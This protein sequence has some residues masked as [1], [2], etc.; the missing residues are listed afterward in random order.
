MILHPRISASTKILGEVAPEQVQPNAID[1]CV[2]GVEE[3]TDDLFILSEDKEE[4]KHRGRIKEPVRNDGYYWLW[5]GNSYAVQLDEVEIG[6]EESGLMIPRS[7]LIRN[8]VLLATGL[9]DSG[10]KGV[11]VTT[12]HVTSGLFKVKPATRIAQLVVWKAESL[13]NYSGQYQAKP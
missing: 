6:K 10:F 2:R 3:I 11:A 12:L 1:L 9:Y 7:S 4:V 13:Y 8:G 5:P